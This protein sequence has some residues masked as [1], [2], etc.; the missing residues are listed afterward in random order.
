MKATHSPAS[1]C[2]ASQQL[3]PQV[4]GKDTRAS[5]HRRCR[6][7]FQQRACHVMPSASSQ[8]TGSVRS[9]LLVQAFRIALSRVPCSRAISSEA[10]SLWFNQV[11]LSCVR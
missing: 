10:S 8:T 11:K 9:D 6:R 3:G 1:T 5:S 2:H 7:Q 4:H